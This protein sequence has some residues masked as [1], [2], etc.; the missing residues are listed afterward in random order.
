MAKKRERNLPRLVVLPTG[1]RY[2]LGIIKVTESD[3]QSPKVNGYHMPRAGEILRC[4]ES[5]DIQGGERFITCYLPE[6]VFGE[7]L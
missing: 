7:F 2:R 6:T 5:T 1:E 3:E 4:D